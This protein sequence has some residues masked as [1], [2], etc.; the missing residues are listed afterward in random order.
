MSFA[1]L[2]PEE[3]NLFT[4]YGERLRLHHEATQKYIDGT[5]TNELLERLGWM[6][7]IAAKATKAV[8]DIKQA[9]AARAAAQVAKRQKLSDMKND[10]VR[11]T[12]AVVEKGMFI[13]KHLD[14]GEA[15][16]VINDLK[17]IGGK[18]AALQKQVE[19]A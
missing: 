8:A 4:Q 2:S 5:N 12:D 1:N 18:L 19:E 7:E 6:T 10:I 17:E 11:F 13:R 3:Q 15:A 16:R 9:S 14:D